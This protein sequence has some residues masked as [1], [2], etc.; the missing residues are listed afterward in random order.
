MSLNLGFGLFDRSISHFS[1]ARQLSAPISPQDFGHTFVAPNVAN[2][3]AYVQ[4]TNGSLASAAQ[5]PLQTIDLS[6]AECISRS[7][8]AE[9]NATGLLR[10]TSV[11]TEVATL[12]PAAKSGSDSSSFRLEMVTEQPATCNSL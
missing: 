5:L 9:T 11:R 4:L 12:G 6:G 7:R 3:G 2:N 1:L 8:Q 10:S